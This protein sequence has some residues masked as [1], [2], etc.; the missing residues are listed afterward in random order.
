MQG[1]PREFPLKSHA[2][3]KRDSCQLSIA[4]HFLWTTRQNEINRQK[5]FQPEQKTL[6]PQV[7]TKNNG[8]NTPQKNVQL[9]R[10]T[11]QCFQPHHKNVF[12]NQNCAFRI[13]NCATINIIHSS[14]VYGHNLPNEEYQ[15]LLINLSLSPSL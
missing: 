3:F 2:N 13:R 6:Q 1:K 5:W 9:L 11:K 10:L 14:Y 8:F 7:S 12:D 15:L 4:W